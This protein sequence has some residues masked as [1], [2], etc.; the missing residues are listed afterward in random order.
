MNEQQIKEFRKNYKQVLQN[1]Q[2]WER[3]RREHPRKYIKDYYYASGAEWALHD[4][5]QTL[6]IEL[7]DENF[8]LIEE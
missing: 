7:C 2:D 6:G 3:Q 5:A 4:M 1:E 8:K